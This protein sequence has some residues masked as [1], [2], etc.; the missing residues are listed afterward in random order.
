MKKIITSIIILCTF[1]FSV[2]AGNWFNF[3]KTYAGVG[4]GMYMCNYVGSD[5]KKVNTIEISTIC[6]GAMVD[7]AFKVPVFIP[8]CGQDGTYEA[9]KLVTVKVGYMFPVFDNNKVVVRVGPYWYYSTQSFGTINRDNGGFKYTY[10][11]YRSGSF[12]G[13]KVSVGFNYKI[14]FNAY[15]SADPN[16]VSFGFLFDIPFNFKKQNN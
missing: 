5:F 3:R 10:G 7:C 15:V 16:S 6:C 13:G 9:T 2:N 14:D 11:G 1:T 12:I 8:G 4:V